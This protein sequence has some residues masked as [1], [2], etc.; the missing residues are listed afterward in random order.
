MEHIA[1]AAIDWMDGRYHAA[2][3]RW[4]S[5]TW[6]RLCLWSIDKFHA[7]YGHGPSL[8]NN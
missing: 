7:R 5:Q 3:W 4:S 6:V 8:S 2:R 1:N